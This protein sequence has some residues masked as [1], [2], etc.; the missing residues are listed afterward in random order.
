MVSL[1]K[2][3]IKLPQIFAR[4]VRVKVFL[5]FT[6]PLMCVVMFGMIYYPTLQKEQGLKQAIA[7]AKTLSEMLTV[8]VEAGLREGNSSLV[9]ATFQW[10]K[11]N[12][13][14]VCI[15]ILNS[16]SQP[17][18][19]YNPLGFPVQ[20]PLK[21]TET[22][23]SV[24][25]EHIVVVS[26]V[27][28]RGHFMAS[29]FLVVSLDEVNASIQREQLISIAV[30]IIMFI[31]GIWGTVLLSNQLSDL[32]RSNKELTTRKNQLS[33]AQAIANLGSWEW[34]IATG[35]L[36]WSKELFHIFGLDHEQTQPTYNKFLSC[37]HPDDRDF[38][39]QNI[40]LALNDKQAY[41]VE[42]RVVRPTN[43][44]RHIAAGGK[45]E[46][47]IHGRPLR[48]VG[49]ALDITEQKQKEESLKLFRTLIDSSNDA[50]EIIDLET[51]RFLDVN[52]RECENLGYS[53]EEL[54]SMRFFDIAPSH[55]QSAFEANKALLIEAG[56]VIVEGVHQRKDGTTFPVEVSLRVIR[57]DR[58]YL[59]AA[60]RDITR[61]KIQEEELLTAK[62]VAEE[63]AVILRA[64]ADELTKAH[65]T[66]LRASKMKSEFVANMS[67]EIRTP[68]NGVIGMTSL[69]WDTELTAEQREFVNI[70]RTSG[71]A[72]LTIIND[73][74]DFSKIE[75]GKLS[76]EI[77]D[78]DLTTII[79]ETVDL[80]T[81]KAQQ[82]KFE[83]LYLVDHNVPSALRGDPGRIRQ[84]LLNLLSNA[85]KF[86]EQGEVFLRVSLD[87]RSD[88]GAKLRFSI[89]DTG[90]GISAEAQ[91]RLFR[92][93]SQADGSTTRKYGGTGLGLAISKRLTEMMGGSIGVESEPGK[94]STF[95]FVI[96]F[97]L[98]RTAV[99]RQ[100]ASLNIRGMR[101]L[102]VDDNAA[103]RTILQYQLNSWGIRQRCVENGAKALLALRS[104]IQERDPFV[105]AILDMQMPE[106]DG[107]ALA[108]NIKNDP[109]LA[110]TQ[111]IML[112]SVGTV[113]KP[114]VEKAGIEALLH[115]PVKQSALLDCISNVLGSSSAGRVHGAAQENFS[116]K[117]E[118]IMIQST[119]PLRVLVAED[120]MV[121]QKVTARM[122]SKIGCRIDMV[123]NGYEA[124]DA[125]KQVPYDIILMD[126]QMPEM[127]GFEA[128]AE[129]RR[130]ERGIKHTTIIAMTANALQGD[131]ERCI[132]AGMDE[133]IAKPVKL[134]E[135]ARILQKW[136]VPHPFTRPSVRP[137]KP[138][139]DMTQ[140]NELRVLDEDGETGI[141]EQIIASYLEESK[142]RIVSLQKSVSEKDH[143]TLKRSL[144]SFK[145]DSLSLGAAALAEQ[146][147]YLEEHIDDVSQTELLAHI[148]Q[149]ERE[150]FQ[151]EILLKKTMEIPEVES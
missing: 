6:L 126:C 144:H 107:L 55:P 82:K 72:L 76:L 3:K 113:D 61:R 101:V 136:S 27:F 62:S 31:I 33:E 67:H 143:S 70:I 133:Y 140:L 104:A 35:A 23:V 122:L 58:D 81:P 63:R 111:L 12:T 99:E 151:V 25:Q 135:L 68:L 73:I 79:E 121:N 59:I 116:E 34:D 129:I 103:N 109:V 77:I 115:K 123:A 149:L 80:L 56:S 36:S 96:P 50:L 43:E 127:D 60:V 1:T 21:L 102:V 142:K 45:V 150:F 147:Q 37:T 119:T 139:L 100:T 88:D 41:N 85:I 47:D 48:M 14:V 54:L 132:E 120:N 17:V 39:K 118:T 46:R 84:I 86:T 13:S 93:F 15:S 30:Y 131:R 52:E 124:V 112:T 32:E 137:S 66:A 19:E 10:A 138:S 83:F 90:T 7:N 110:D 44:V 95:W 74:L 11:K 22:K 38:V 125:L 117:K 148:G 71:D 146:C 4:S 105:L 53:R 51:G 2:F 108:S 91:G 57:L 128:S 64:Q 29:V 114:V 97:E 9:R 87:S 8:S 24:E 78:F 65:E 18:L 141:L 20:S 106:M 16:Q 134:D 92:S 75:A 42:F 94:G 89:H 49:T 98:G 69:L 26:P 40:S 28:D 130:Q 145:G 5:S